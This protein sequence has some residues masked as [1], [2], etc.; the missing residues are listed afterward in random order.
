M[1][2]IREAIREDNLLE[3]RDAFFEEYGYNEPNARTFWVWN[4]MKMT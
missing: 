3:F 1:E 2:Q 4:P